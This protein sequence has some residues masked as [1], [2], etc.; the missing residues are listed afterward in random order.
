[1]A[2]ILEV[3]GIRL[4]PS[5]V[6]NYARFAAAIDSKPSVV[7]RAI[8]EAVE[9]YIVRTAIRVE[10]ARASGRVTPLGLGALL[11]GLI[12]DLASMGRASRRVSA[13]EPESEPDTAEA[14]S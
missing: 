14:M 11:G 7:Q 4:R 9:P 5:T 3:V 10:R 8:L 6:A 13:D 1:M 12:A 2:E